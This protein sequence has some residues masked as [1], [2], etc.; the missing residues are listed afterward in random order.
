MMVLILLICQVLDSKGIAVDILNE[1]YVL[2]INTSLGAWK[3]INQFFS[4]HVAASMLLGVITAT[5]ISKNVHLF[6]LKN[7]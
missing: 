6:T 7:K 3:K 5:Y 1:W 4:E 2:E